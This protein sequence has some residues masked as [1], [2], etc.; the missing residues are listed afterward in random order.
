[1]F[2]TTRAQ[3]TQIADSIGEGAHQFSD[4]DQVWRDDNGRYFIGSENELQQAIEDGDT[5]DIYVSAGIVGDYA[6]K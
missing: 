4:G 5:D 6:S 2:S 3:L 1:M